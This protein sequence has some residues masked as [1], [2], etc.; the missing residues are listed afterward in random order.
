MP[1]MLSA[2]QFAIGINGSS[3]EDQHVQQSSEVSSGIVPHFRM[4]YVFAL[5]FFLPLVLDEDLFYE[6]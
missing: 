3:P 5:P 6:L 1:V 4:L 2:W